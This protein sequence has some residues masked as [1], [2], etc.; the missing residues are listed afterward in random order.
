[1]KKNIYHQ[2][3]TKKQQK[4]S[5]IP[6]LSKVFLVLSVVFFAATIFTI[7][8]YKHVLYFG[9]FHRPLGSHNSVDT[10][11]YKPAEMPTFEV[12]SSITKYTL[13]E[14]DTQTINVS[15]QTSKNT[16]VHMEI[17]IK[18]PEGKQIFKSPEDQIVQ[19]S[20]GQNKDFTYSYIMPKDSAKGTY[21][22]SCI[23]NSENEFT[24]YYINKRFAKFQLL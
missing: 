9:F 24:D 7:Q 23:I 15:A 1:M 20:A 19:F 10:R 5:K 13:S 4:I 6:M 17:W 16:A 22:V 11:D 2:K 18:N 3:A 8:K 14:G 21:E 12:K